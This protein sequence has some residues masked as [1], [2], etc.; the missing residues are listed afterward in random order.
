[1]WGRPPRY[2][3]ARNGACPTCGHACAPWYSSITNALGDVLLG[4]AYWRAR[5]LQH[6][7][8]LS[9]D[10]LVWELRVTADRERERANYATLSQSALSTDLLWFAECQKAYAELELWKRK[11]EGVARA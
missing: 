4:R 10:P 11:A 2:T 3:S 7:V 6:E 5:A 1:M 9:R 8:Y